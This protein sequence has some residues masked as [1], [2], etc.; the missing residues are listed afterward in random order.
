MD[1]PRDGN[2]ER[3]ERAIDAMRQAPELGEFPAD[4]VLRNIQASRD[5]RRRPHTL[6]TRRWTMKTYSRLAAMILLA[7]GAAAFAWIV[8]KPG[9]SVAF[10]EVARQLHE[11]RTLTADMTTT[12][13]DGK[14]VHSRLYY[15]AAGR[16]RIE[17]GQTVTITDIGKHVMLTLDRAQKRAAVFDASRKP[18]TRPAQDPSEF[19]DQLLH[20]Q[21]SGGKPVGEK[22]VNGRRATGFEID[23]EGQH[24]L[25]WADAK[26]GEPLRLEM[27]IHTGPA[28]KP[29]ALVMD[30]LTINPKLDNALFSTQVPA[31][32]T[33]ERIALSIP[34]GKP[35]EQDVVE[36]L[37]QYAATFDGSFPP[38]LQPAEWLAPLKQRL[39]TGANAQ[40]PTTRPAPQFLVLLGLSGRVTQFLETLPHG[41]HYA[42]TGLRPGDSS[43]IIFWYRPD[44]SDE[45]RAVYAN[46][47][48]ATVA[49]D[50]LPMEPAK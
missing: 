45:Y 19:L 24:A 10:A 13:F 44:G 9:G 38:G 37:R 5:A 20:V 43:K 18:D 39:A 36:F 29:I 1:R 31:G 12:P 35:G 46:L 17:S 50:Q 14:P 40:N 25:V 7:I 6:L 23:Q 30:D 16:Y 49:Q 11:T 26:T 3:L 8:L 2:D 21:A 41:Y 33:Q 15:D 27:S 28:Q 4:A 48:A 47:H 32:Y 42:A 34:T 22:D